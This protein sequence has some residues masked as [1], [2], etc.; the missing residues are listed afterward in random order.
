MNDLLLSAL[1]ETQREYKE[2]LKW[3]R[4]L[5]FSQNMNVVLI[6]LASFWREHKKLVECAL[7]Y[8]SKPYDK[9]FFTAAT[10]LDIDDEEHVPFLAVGSLHI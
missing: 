1:A 9:F 2:K 3:A 4:E 6:E 7:N 10:I 8:L 5:L